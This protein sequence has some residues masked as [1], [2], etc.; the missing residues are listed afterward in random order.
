[1]QCAPC[2]VTNPAGTKFCGE[3]DHPL[4][5]RCPSCGVQ[6]RLL[7]KFCGYCRTPLRSRAQS[8]HPN[9]RTRTATLSPN[10][11]THSPPPA[12]TATSHPLAPDAERR[13]LTVM[14]CDLVDSTALSAALDPEELR[15][16]VRAY[17]QTCA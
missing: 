9:N 10:T 8:A 5:N 6:N 16:I 17:H 2:G 12:T 4:T 15:D 3:C 7:L 13:Q 1:M 11:A 14:F